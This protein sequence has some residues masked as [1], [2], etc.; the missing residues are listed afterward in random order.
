MPLQNRVSPYSTIHAV[1]ARGMLMGNRGRLHQDSKND[2]IPE[3]ITQRWK[4]ISWISCALEY[5]G[6]NRSPLMQPGSYTELFF[7]DEVTALAA[8]HRPCALC[9]RER[10]GRFLDAWQEWTTNDANEITKNSRPSAKEVDHRLHTERVAV[11][12]QVEQNDWRSLDTIPDYAMFDFHGKAHVKLSEKKILR[13]THFGYEP[14]VDNVA[15][16]LGR[17]E[18][19][20]MLTC[21][22]MC[23]VLQHGY[24]PIIHES[25]RTLQNNHNL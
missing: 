24:V 2:E 11:M 13:W 20:R 6:R 14:L 16:N 21:P 25:A 7:L 15:V 22:S 19:L 17:D 4:T 23:S 12:D 1:G 9:S 10:Y 5:K 3:L 8:G 18:E